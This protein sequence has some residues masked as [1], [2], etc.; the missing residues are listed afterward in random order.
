[1]DW[2]HFTLITITMEANGGNVT[3][4]YTA[5]MAYA[6]GMA[7]AADM[8]AAACMAYNDSTAAEAALALQD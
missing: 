7:Y 8:A 4:A 3:A 1:M 5:C 2:F 6:A